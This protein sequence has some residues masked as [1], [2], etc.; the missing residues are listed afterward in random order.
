MKL[1]RF[2]KAKDIV[3]RTTQQPTAWEK[4]KPALKPHPIEGYIP[5]YIRYSRS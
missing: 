5:K 1:E 4:K 2:C 3:N